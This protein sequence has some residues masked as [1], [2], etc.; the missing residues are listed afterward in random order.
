MLKEEFI[1]SQEAIGMNLCGVTRSFSFKFCF[2]SESLSGLALSCQN[3][4]NSGQ[5]FCLSI[6]FMKFPPSFL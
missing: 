1:A 6:N 5:I 3:P 4:H 2:C